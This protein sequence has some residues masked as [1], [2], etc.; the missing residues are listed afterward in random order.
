M[1][2]IRRGLD[3]PITGNPEQVISEAPAVSSVALVGADY[4]GLKP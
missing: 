4:H 2:N 3:L 1:I